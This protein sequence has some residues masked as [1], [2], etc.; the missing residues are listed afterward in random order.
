M[1]QLCCQHGRRFD[2]KRVPTRVLIAET[3]MASSARQASQL[4]KVARHEAR[5]IRAHRTAPGCTIVLDSIDAHS[6]PA[7]IDDAEGVLL[8]EHVIVDVP[9]ER[10][11]RPFGS[12][13]TR[14]PELEEFTKEDS[15]A[16]GDSL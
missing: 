5:C 2:G 15:E 3:G 9:L 16:F 14:E 7:V 12:L 11:A 13:P 4:S 1:P 10:P 8:S 6:D